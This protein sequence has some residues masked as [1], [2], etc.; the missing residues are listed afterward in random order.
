[1]M[2][3]EDMIHFFLQLFVSSEATKNLKKLGS[4]KDFEK[5]VSELVQT[6]DTEEVINRFLKSVRE[7][8]SAEKDA[9]RSKKARCEGNKLYK[10]CHTMDDYYDLFKSYN[11][12]IA[13]A[14]NKS[15][16]MALSYANRAM[17]MFRLKYYTECLADINRAVAAK[18]PD[19]SMANLLIKK[20]RCMKILNHP[21][22]HVVYK[23]SLNWI[24]QHLSNRREVQAEIKKAYQEEASPCTKTMNVVPVREAVLEEMTKSCPNLDKIEIQKNSKGD[25]VLVAT[26]DMEAGEVVAMQ[27]IYTQIFN[28]EFPYLSCGECIM[29]CVNP[30]PCDSCSKV[31]YCTESCKEK[32]WTKHHE[33]ECQIMGLL[34]ALSWHLYIPTMICIYAMKQI[35]GISPLMRE[36]YK[37]SKTEGSFKF[38]FELIQIIKFN[39]T[40]NQISYFNRRY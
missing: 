37:M 30:I 27:K 21:D 36:A 38:Y 12:S 40:F 13:Y 26:K 32:A 17:V 23:D 25:L 8:P 39:C 5:M 15:E 11:E 14:P 4:V 31:M 29:M 2:S 18:C 24:N 1:M 3:E 35:G 10:K 20:V 34:Q 33:Y 16:E 22:L 9:V 19:D 28:V 7:K 6:I